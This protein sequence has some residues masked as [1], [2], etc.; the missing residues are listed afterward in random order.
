M[1]FSANDQLV[2]LCSLIYFSIG[3]FN[4]FQ[5]MQ[6]WGVGVFCVCYL[7][8]AEVWT[9][10]PLLMLSRKCCRLLYIIYAFINS[11]YVFNTSSFVFCTTSAI[12]EHIFKHKHI[13]LVTHHAFICCNHVCRMH[14]I[15]LSWLYYVL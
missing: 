5:L 13:Y 8:H 2:W 12:H 11:Y 14:C 10:S 3:F 15:M 1:C 9:Q 4:P 6:S 7:L